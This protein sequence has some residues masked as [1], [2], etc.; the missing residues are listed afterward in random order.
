LKVGS[1]RG[2][3]EA[4]K[5]SRFSRHSAAFRGIP[6]HFA[7]FRGISLHFAAFRG[8]PRH[9]AA[10]RGISRHSAAFRDFRGIPRTPAGTG[11]SRK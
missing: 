1:E 2:E 11:T 3:G 7:A 6:R 9:S 10:F 4:P 5:K 8:I